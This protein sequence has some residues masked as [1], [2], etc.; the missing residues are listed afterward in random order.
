MNSGQYISQ[1]ET[2]QIFYMQFEKDADLPEHEH[3]NQIGFVWECKIE[4]TIS[5]KKA[6]Y[7]KGDRY[8][9]PAGIKHFAKIFAGYSDF[10]IFMQPSKYKKTNT[11]Q[12]PGSQ[13]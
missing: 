11:Y 2:Y 1:A 10:T 7:S 5:G 3:E 6:S 13:G 8:H 4:L 9:I 12:E